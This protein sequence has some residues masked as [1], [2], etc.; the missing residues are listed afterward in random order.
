MLYTSIAVQLQEMHTRGF[1]A[2]ESTLEMF[3][4]ASDDE[5]ICRF[6]CGDRQDGNAK[7][8]EGSKNPPKLRR[9]SSTAS[10][11]SSIALQSASTNP[12]VDFA[13][14]RSLESSLLV[15]Q[16]ELPQREWS[17]LVSVSE[18]SSIILYL[19]DAEKLLLQPRRMCKLFDR[20]LKKLSGNVLILGSWTLELDDDCKEV[21]ERLVMLFPYNIEIKP[22]ED[23][24]HLVSWK[25]QL[26]ED[27][28][29]IQ[30]QD[31]KNHIGRIGYE[32]KKVDHSPR[33]NP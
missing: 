32:M 6:L 22:P 26:E 14:D 8:M 18:R 21:D 12:V 19:T 16:N 20:M 10:D 4:Q 30:F 9:N 23:E 11:I 7:G 29:K 27:M 24:T 2:D 31:N 33:I 17:V 3:D 1:S 25:A 5:I 15:D 28:K 13:E